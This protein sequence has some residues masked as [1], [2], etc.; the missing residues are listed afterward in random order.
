MACQQFSALRNGL[1]NVAPQMQCSSLSVTSLAGPWFSS[2]CSCAPPP[3]SAM[4]G[5][6][7]LFD[8]HPATSSVNGRSGST[9]RRRS[10][11]QPGLG[12]QRAKDYVTALVE[13]NVSKA[14]P[15]PPELNYVLSNAPPDLQHKRTLSGKGTL[16]T[17]RGHPRLR[18][19]SQ[20]PLRN[21]S[22]DLR[23][24]QRLRPL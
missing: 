16:S 11:W 1:K 17:A 9:R 12:I 4:W 22:S 6:R 23:R 5:T 3:T 2:P 21:A 18:R 10:R 7:A 8:R 19:F 14:W 15:A 24:L 20:R 13:N